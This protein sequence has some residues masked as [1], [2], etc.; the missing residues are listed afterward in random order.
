MYRKK[1]QSNIQRSNSSDGDASSSDSSSDDDKSPRLKSASDVINSFLQRNETNEIQSTN[2]PKLRT[3][4]DVINSFLQKKTTQTNRPPFQSAL[5][6]IN[7][8][9]Q[10]DNCWGDKASSKRKR[11]NRKTIDS[12]T[13]DS[14]SSEESLNITNAAKKRKV[15][16]SHLTKDQRSL[17]RRSVEIRNDKSTTSLSCDTNL[18]EDIVR[19]TEN[20][21]TNCPIR[22]NTRLQTTS[23]MNLPGNMNQSKKTT[24]SSS[25]AANNS[26]PE[27]KNRVVIRRDIQDQMDNTIKYTDYHVAKLTSNSYN[28]AILIISNVISLT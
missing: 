25:S 14:D 23:Q 1:Q 20:L 15:E 16:T 26:N 4:S 28:I 17:A 18:S 5:D 7:S 6:V 10:S 11:T 12:S 8:Y 13:S 3:A 22:R 9:L 27:T 24:K 2:V 21:S 19:L